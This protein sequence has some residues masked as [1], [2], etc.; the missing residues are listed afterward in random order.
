M[1]EHIHREIGQAE[2]GEIALIRHDGGVYPLRGQAM[3]ITIVESI[4]NPFLTCRVR[5]NDGIGLLES[6]RIIGEEHIYIEFKTK[7]DEFNMVKKFFRVQGIDER[8]KVQ[9]RGDIFDIVAISPEYYRNRERQIETSFVGI[10]PS[11]I[12]TNIFNEYLAP[13]PQ[14]AADSPALSKPFNAWKTND[15]ITI[16]GN[17]RS[18]LRFIEELAQ[19]SHAFQQDPETGDR[20]IWADYLFFENLDGFYFYPES[21][22]RLGYGGL[23]DSFFYTPASLPGQ[24]EQYGDKF[25]EAKAKIEKAVGKL[26]RKIQSGELKDIANQLGSSLGAVTGQLA[27][28]LEASAGPMTQ[29]LQQGAQSLKGVLGSISNGVIVDGV[30]KPRHDELDRSRREDASTI[31]QQLE[32]LQ[33]AD[34]YAMNQ[35]GLFRNAVEIVDPIR[36]MVRRHDWNYDEQFEEIGHTGI[37]QHK[38]NSKNS[39]YTRIGSTQLTHTK[40]GNYSR[41][42]YRNTAYIKDSIGF[43]PALDPYL[44][45]ADRDHFYQPHRT[46][47]WAG[48]DNI[49]VAITIPG[50]SMT[51]AGQ[52]IDVYLPSTISS[53]EGKNK[54]EST[55][56]NS[57]GSQFLCQTVTH[58]I[59]LANEKYSTAITCIKD[60]YANDVDNLTETASLYEF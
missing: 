34:Q 49:V 58:T 44:Y 10:T 50:H 2:V 19:R 45:F 55:F 3:S 9:S 22:L 35:K 46:A 23:G 38:I 36:K 15:L 6:F 25:L 18:P 13:N 48:D 40:V 59:N 33:M 17:K 42:M 12:A 56:T 8:V 5:I 53:E 1:A 14:L 32:I 24:T 29:A 43:D 20:S 51:R 57:M 7:T 30:G 54:W 47:S 60:S 21:A 39:D 27:G 31:I 28:A 37:Q 26:E 16:N 11:D 52:I 41:G 4:I